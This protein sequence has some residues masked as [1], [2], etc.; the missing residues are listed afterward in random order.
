[1][2]QATDFYNIAC[3]AYNG[4]DDA[5]AGWFDLLAPAAEKYGKI[6]G[7]L[8]SLILAK[9]AIETGY[10]SDLYDKVLEHT[11]NIR[12]DGKAQRHNNIL[13]VN[14]FA[15]NR[16]YLNDL[17]I[18]TWSILRYEFADY[19]LHFDKS[20]KGFVKMELWK[21]YQTVE[22]CIEDWCA[23]IRYQA[24]ANNRPWSMDLRG[25]LLAIES[26]TPEGA[27]S[28]YPGMHF[29]WQDD[30]I[31]LYIRYQLYKYDKG[32]RSVEKMTAA[33]LDK[34]IKK[35]YE[36]AHK[37]CDYGRSDLSYPPGENGFLD[38][39]GLVYRA[40]YT[41]GH[42]THAM[43]I[44]QVISLCTGLDMKKSTDINDVWLHH[45]V[46]CMQD[47]NNRGTQH[48]N[49]VYYSLGGTS[50]S[51]ITKFDTGSRERIRSAQPFTRVPVNQWP[52]R[53]IFLCVLYL[54]DDSP[55]GKPIFIGTTKKALTLRELPGKGN[56]A[57]CNVPAKSKVKVYGVINTSRLNRWYF[58]S[59]GE[60]FGYCYAGSVTHKKYTIPKVYMTVKTPDNSLTCRV[61]AG[62]DYPIFKLCPA[63][64]NGAKLRFINRLTA[65]DGTIWFNVYR[66][67]LRFFVSGAWLK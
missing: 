18:P 25:Q 48:V 12:M 43:N 13:C 10:G 21:D 14:G 30:I 29:D 4:S 32:V 60:H 41:M 67:G 8:P 26:Y 1:M 38:C 19:G 61:G 20:G 45:G 37:Y 3:A 63:V 55:V 16:K 35:A 53:R 46:V 64:K 23:N 7:V 42:Y 66:G 40:L 49:H 24:K 50:V 15:E 36:F 62:V 33:N 51:N 27:A 44:D 17:P 6:Y 47:K 59:F 9:A 5:R 31:D 57:V 54:P 56:A 65:A 2:M 52:D 22:D 58:V 11:Y 34:N 39:V 28:K